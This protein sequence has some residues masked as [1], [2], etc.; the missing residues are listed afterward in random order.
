VQTVRI[1]YSDYVNMCGIVTRLVGTYV[2]ILPS[3]A[4]PDVLGHGVS[5]TTHVTVNR[6]FRKPFRFSFSA[7][8]LHACFTIYDTL[9]RG[10]NHPGLKGSAKF[11]DAL[12]LQFVAPRLKVDKTFHIGYSNQYGPPF[13]SSFDFR[14]RI[15]LRPASLPVVQ[16]ND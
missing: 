6:T 16:H 9:L 14:K 2:P 15:P 11:A 3:F 7:V 10:Y 12:D 4:T 13:Q 8:T 5:I 1:H